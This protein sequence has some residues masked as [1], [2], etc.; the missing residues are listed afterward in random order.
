MADLK[1]PA[2]RMRYT[3]LAKA[4]ESGTLIGKKNT[5]SQGVPES[6]NEASKKRKKTAFDSEDDEEGSQKTLLGRGRQA[7][8]AGSLYEGL[9]GRK[10]A[11]GDKVDGSPAAKKRTKLT[12]TKA[13]AEDNK[14][15]NISAGTRINGPKP[16]KSKISPFTAA[17]A[18]QDTDLPPGTKSPA[19][20]D[21]TSEDVSPSSINK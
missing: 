7:S 17:K 16:A 15:E 19:F 21:P 3:R 13:A 5:S 14:A 12:K 4:I 2:A 11:L 9:K 20:P 6:P 10:N 8:G 1:A 18:F